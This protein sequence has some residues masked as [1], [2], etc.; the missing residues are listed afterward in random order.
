MS[1]LELSADNCIWGSLARR[2]G[3][4]GTFACTESTGGRL[5]NQWAL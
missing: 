3:I 2:L 4:G 5:D 1:E